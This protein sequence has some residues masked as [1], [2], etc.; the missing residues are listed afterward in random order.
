MQRGFLHLTQRDN[1]IGILINP[2]EILYVIGGKDATTI[3]M[4]DNVKH[5]VSQD[6]DTVEKLFASTQ[7]P[8]DSIA[9]AA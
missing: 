2:A 3:Y 1:G 8:M 4:R 5:T 7:L 6:V 9:Q